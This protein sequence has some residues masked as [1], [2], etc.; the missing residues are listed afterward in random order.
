MRGFEIHHLRREVGPELPP[1]VASKSRR[2]SALMI[3]RPRACMPRTTRPTLV[4]LGRHH[5]PAGDIVRGIPA[6]AFLP[7]ANVSQ[8][9]GHCL[10]RGRNTTRRSWMCEHLRALMRPRWKSPAT[11]T[12]LSK[13]GSWLLRAGAATNQGSAAA[14]AAAGSMNDCNA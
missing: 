9:K 14:P 3:V 1:R 5:S 10:F 4:Q 2:V 13:A 12:G 11:G 6:T 7:A 8:A